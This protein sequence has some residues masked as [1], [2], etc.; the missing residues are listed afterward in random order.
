MV[1]CIGSSGRAAPVSFWSSMLMPE[2]MFCE[3]KIVFACCYSN[4]GRGLAQ[5]KTIG[6]R[7]FVVMQIS[8]ME[9]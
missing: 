7:L 8:T 9:K 2:S 5:R 6:C 3:M 1:G 4:R